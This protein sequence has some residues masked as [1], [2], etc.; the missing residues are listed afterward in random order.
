M[1]KAPRSPRKTSIKRCSFSQLL[2]LLGA[3]LPRAVAGATAG[4]GLSPL[5]TPRL[6]IY[7]PERVE[8]GTQNGAFVLSRK[9]FSGEC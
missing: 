8:T 5:V 3:L 7:R 2:F 4:S 9:I 6:V 1:D